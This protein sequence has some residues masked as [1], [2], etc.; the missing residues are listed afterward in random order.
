MVSTNVYRLHFPLLQRIIVFG[1]M[2]IMSLVGVGLI[3]AATL[4]RLGG[5]PVPVLLL[6]LAAVGW[7]WFVL[8]GIPYEIRFES[9]DRVSFKALARTA[10]VNASEI[11]SI[12]PYGGGFG[13]G[14]LF[15]LRHDGGK[16]RLV[17][18]FTG[19]HEVISRIKAAH[20]GIEVIGI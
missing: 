3:V 15:I 19:F 2:G 17:A 12:K 1:T 9:A 10:T 4:N 13:S 5:T 6:W 11:Q 7:N 18:Q 20:P 14:P 8:L 16:I